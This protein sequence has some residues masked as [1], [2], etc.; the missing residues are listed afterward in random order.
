MRVEV[1]QYLNVQ[2]NTEKL[3]LVKQAIFSD[4]FIT[5]LGSNELLAAKPRYVKTV[6]LNTKNNTVP[7]NVFRKAFPIQ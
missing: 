5:A 1:Q 6:T 4:S 7:K 3:E 2:I